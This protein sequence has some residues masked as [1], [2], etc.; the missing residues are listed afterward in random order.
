MRRFILCAFLIMLGR[1]CLAQPTSFYGLKFGEKYTLDEMIAAIGENGTYVDHER[2]QFADQI[3]VDTFFFT[4]VE[5]GDSHFPIMTL[6]FLP[7]S[8]T[9][10]AASFGFLA[11][12][13]TTQE[14]LERTY[15]SI[16]DSLQTH[17]SMITVPLDDPSVTRMTSLGSFSPSLVRLDRFTESG[18]ITAIE[19]TYLSIFDLAFELLPDEPE[20]PDIQDTFLG[21][22]MGEKYGLSQVKS[23]LSSRGTYLSDNRD[24][25]GFRYTFKNVSFAGRTWSYAE[26]LLTADSRLY[27][28]SFYDSLDN[29]SRE[30]RTARSDFN[31]LKEKLDDKYG[32]ADTNVDDEENMSAFY[33]G[34]NDVAAN[35]SFEE[36]KS[37]GGLYRVYLKLTYVQTELLNEVNQ[38]SD[39][40]L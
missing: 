13:E 6:Q 7:N 10:L 12:E 16:S 37:K 17:Y 28:V 9:L 25:N 15:K 32:I 33:L 34:G 18:L 3:D 1:I 5:F 19:L 40:E 38:M 27:Y 4:D 26:L 21:L 29:T 2:Q 11:D 14:L 35:L 39:D 22:K 31:S 36:A 23:A 24:A 8:G 20:R 30:K